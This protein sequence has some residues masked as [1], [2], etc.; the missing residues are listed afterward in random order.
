M[1]LP[2][3][4]FHSVRGHP[5]DK[6]PD[7]CQLVSLSAPW[8]WELRWIPEPSRPPWHQN[9][10]HGLAH[11]GIHSY[12]LIDLPP[13][14]LLPPSQQTQP[15]QILTLKA[16][17]SAVTSPLTLLSAPPSSPASLCPSLLPLLSTS[18]SPGLL[19]LPARL[20]AVPSPGKLVPRVA[21]L[22]RPHSAWP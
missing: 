4:G 20:R 15:L 8:G 13:P 1:L 12:V 2:A 5:L 6:Y 14:P 9:I 17:P 11:A 22:G 18:G 3:C 21:A 7:P 10:A 16:G 19:L